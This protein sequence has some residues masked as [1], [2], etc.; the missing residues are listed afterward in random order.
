LE[1]L[2]DRG[3]DVRRLGA[4]PRRGQ[5]GDRQGPPVRADRTPSRRLGG[6]HPRGAEGGTGSPSPAARRSALPHRRGNTP[7]GQGGDPL[8]AL[9]D[10]RAVVERGAGLAA[11]W[12]TL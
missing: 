12:T 9:P 7:R 5:G 10:P 2:A 3:T 8:R 1:R 6:A 4:L 11:S